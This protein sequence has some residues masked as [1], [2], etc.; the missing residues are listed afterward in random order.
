MSLF[1]LNPDFPDFWEPQSD[2]LKLVPLGPDVDADEYERVC[3]RFQQTMPHVEL[4]K[5]ERIQN[6]PAWRMYQDHCCQMLEHG[7]GVL[8]EKLLFHGS[9]KTNPEKIYAGRSSFDPMYSNDGMWG[10]G[11][12]FAEN[13]SYSDGFSW[14][15]NTSSGASIR[16]VLVA[17]VLTGMS[18]T[19]VPRHFKEPPERPERRGGI[20]QRY[21]SV[22][23][24]T[25]GSKVYITYKYNK[26]YPAY[27]I[28]YRK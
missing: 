9:G 2:Q 28:T 3:S 13:A 15:L 1:L 17:C 8:G 6:K 22:N 25:W 7:N 16:K 4:L 5:I 18:I 12:Y 19:S 21:D 27:L 26:A 14:H 10:R 20:I 23:G 24:V 11:C